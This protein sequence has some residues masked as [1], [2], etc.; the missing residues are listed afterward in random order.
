MAWK[1]NTEPWPKA[2]LKPSIDKDAKIKKTPRLDGNFPNHIVATA[3]A[4]LG[5][6]IKPPSEVIHLDDS[7]MEEEE[8][9]EEEASFKGGEKRIST[10]SDEDTDVGVMEDPEFSPLGPPVDPK[11]VHMST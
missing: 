7:S 2:E 1:G 3:P 8:E 9:E 10:E 6:A 5:A 11:M 4:Y